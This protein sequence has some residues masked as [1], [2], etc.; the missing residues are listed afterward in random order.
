LGYRRKVKKAPWVIRGAFLH[1]QGQA[2]NSISGIPLPACAG[3]PS[4]GTVAICNNIKNIF[5]GIVWT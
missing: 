5:K 1:P 4:W 3:Q 2:K